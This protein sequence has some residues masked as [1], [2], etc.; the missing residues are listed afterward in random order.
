MERSLERSDIMIIRK[1]GNTIF[2][3][4]YSFWSQLHF[5][6][7][8]FPSHKFWQEVCSTT[9]ISNS[10]FLNFN[11]DKYVP[12]Y[13]CTVNQRLLVSVTFFFMFA[14]TCLH[15]TSDDVML[16]YVTLRHDITWIAKLWPNCRF[17]KTGLV[18]H[19][20]VYTDTNEYGHCN[21]N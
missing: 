11:L 9:F 13:K 3:N 2:E 16:R 8:V 10:Y 14:N 18:D 20:G 17:L 15:A 7:C 5:L 19:I 6:L 12:V 21:R 1:I 4:S